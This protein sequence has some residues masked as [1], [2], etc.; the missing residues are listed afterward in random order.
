MLVDGRRAAARFAHAPSSPI[1]VG[2]A[3]LLKDGAI[4]GGTDCEDASYG[5][6]LCAGDGGTG[7]RQRTGAPRRRDRG[8]AV[9]GGTMG[10]DGMPTGSTVVHQPAGGAGR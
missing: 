8:I 7:D 4:I 3:L 2:A 10:A 5:L 6:P 1:A 9:T